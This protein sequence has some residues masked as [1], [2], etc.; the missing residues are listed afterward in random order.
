MLYEKLR[1]NKVCCWFIIH[2]RYL[3]GVAFIPSG[4][5][6]LVGHRFTQ[7]STSEPIGFFFEGLFQ[8]GFYYNFIGGAQLLA[9]FLLMTQRLA[10]LGTAI[11]C[12]IIV[13]IW[14]ITLSLSFKGTWIITSLMLFAIAVL[15]TWDYQKLKTIFMFD[16][17]PAVKL[18]PEPALYWHV[19]GLVYFVCILLMFLVKTQMVVAQ[20][21]AAIVA[22]T[23]IISQIF[24]YRLYK[25]S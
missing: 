4:L 15:A 11:Y 1:T 23:F 18:Y 8:S 21:C 2:L 5:V 17:L 10:S 24:A 13:N 3:L 22:I 16:R 14:L 19:V 12:C 7:V 25:N 20:I 9:T 6:K